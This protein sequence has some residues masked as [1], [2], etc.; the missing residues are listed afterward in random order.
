MVTFK[1]FFSFKHNRFFW[2]N[3]TAM[4][5]VIVAAAWGTL[6]WLDSYTRHGEAVTVPDVK[7]MNLRGAEN[8]LAGQSLKAI[9][10]DSSYVKG[11]APGA[12]LE[13]NPAGGARVKSGR[14]VYLTV[15]ADSA[16]KVAVPDIMD[17]S[18][19]RQ[20]EAKLHA[21]GFKTT[22]PEYISGEKDWVYSIKYRGRDLQAGEKIPYE[23][24]LTLTVGDGNETMPEDSVP[25]VNEPGT[26]SNG[27]TVEDES[28][29]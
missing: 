6:Q 24:V 15:N 20:A 21:L 29:F 9:V 17:N 23:A 27:R 5:V 18:S 28:W 22:E 19:L 11:T 4:A 26:A 14:T 16:P 10:I 25:V 7:G 12:V 13:Q 1:E 8:K 2:L 3:L